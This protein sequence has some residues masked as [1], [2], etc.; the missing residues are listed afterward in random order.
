MLINDPNGPGQIDV[1]G[2]DLA[3]LDDTLTELRWAIDHDHQDRELTERE[4]D[5]LSGLLR[6]PDALGWYTSDRP[7]REA[8]QYLSEIVAEALFQTNLPKAMAALSEG[9]ELT[10]AEQ[11]AYDAYVGGIAEAVA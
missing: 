2:W 7:V 5:A 1:T 9:R 3:D 10:E 6:E 4:W 11:A 8:T